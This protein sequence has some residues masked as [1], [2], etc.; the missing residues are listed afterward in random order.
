MCVVCP[1]HRWTFRLTDGLLVKPDRGDHNA[2]VFPVQIDSET[3]EILVGFK[4]FGTNLFSC[5]VDDVDF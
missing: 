2:P 3:N 5:N 4:S 1:W